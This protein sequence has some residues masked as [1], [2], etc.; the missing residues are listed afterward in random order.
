MTSYALLTYTHRRNVTAALPIVKWLSKKRNSIGGFSS[1]QVKPLLSEKEWKKA[2]YA[3]KAWFP[4]V[5][6]KTFE[7]CFCSFLNN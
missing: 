2:G 5:I 3:T 6:L 7:L 1:T 4:L